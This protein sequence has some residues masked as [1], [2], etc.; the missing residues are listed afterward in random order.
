VLS[1]DVEVTPQERDLWLDKIAKGVVGRG[2][3]TPAIL[4]LEM[5]KPLS[6][7]ASQGV[8]VM[9]PLVAPFVGFENV[10]LA[11]KL[12]EKRENVELLIRRIEDLSQERKSSPDKSKENASAE[13]AP[14]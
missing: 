8:V 3:E 9:S 7:I 1:W 6:Y 11:V 4:F 10:R 14:S 13:G 12:M 2:M 5:H